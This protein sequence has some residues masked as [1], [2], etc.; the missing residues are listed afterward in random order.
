MLR[1]R[2]LSSHKASTLLSSLV[3]VAGLGG[4]ADYVKRSDTVTFAAGEAQSWN[5]AVHVVDPW[6]PYAA[7]TRIDGDGRRVSRVMER[8]RAGEDGFVSGQTPLP[9][10]KPTND[11]PPSGA[12]QTGPL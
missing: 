1:K 8:Y 5:R 6:P 7:N 12:P 9:T 11:A 10:A 4:C 3:L 2:S